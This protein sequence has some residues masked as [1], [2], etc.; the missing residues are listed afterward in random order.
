MSI[1]TVLPLSTPTGGL[2]RRVAARPL[3]WRN[4]CAASRM[5]ALVLRPNRQLG[6]EGR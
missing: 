1:N 4:R 5:H 6:V 2:A 3:G